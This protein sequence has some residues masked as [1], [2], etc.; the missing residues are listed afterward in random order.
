MYNIAPYYTGIHYNTICRI[1]TVQSPRG[2]NK[3]IGKQVQVQQC[4]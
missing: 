3:V 4:T 2:K 1:S